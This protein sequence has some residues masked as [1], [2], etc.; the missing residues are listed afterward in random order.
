MSRSRRVMVPRFQSFKIKYRMEPAEPMLQDARP[1][2]RQPPCFVHDIT[3]KA[4]GVTVDALH[5]KL[6]EWCK[7]W[8]FQLEKGDGGYLHYQGRVTL[9]KKRRPVEIANLFND[10]LF[11]VRWSV[12]SSNARDKESFYCIK[13]DTKVDGPWKDTDY[14]PPVVLTRQMQEFVNF[15]RYPWQS[16][17]EEFCKEWDK[18][19]I[20]WIYDEGGYNGKSDLVEWLDVNRIACV[21]PPMRNTEDILQFVYC[22]P[23]SRAYLIDFPRSMKKDHLCEFYSGI[24]ALKN[25]FVY[26]KRYKG[27]KRWIDRPAIIIFSNTLPPSAAMSRDRWKVWSIVDHDLSPAS[28]I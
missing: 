5:E 10:D 3:V 13:A 4:E 28:S 2:A 16:K 17:V 12:T 19:T 6:R 1:P 18:R 11:K 15:T 25:G 22:Q 20:H 27:Q 23:D 24:E 26:D 8:I 9:I 7:K 14:R 21:V